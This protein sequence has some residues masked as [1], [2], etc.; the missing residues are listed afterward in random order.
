M[1]IVAQ[2]MRW[3]KKS[4]FG[5]QL[6]ATKANWL[7]SDSTNQSF[8]FVVADLKVSPASGTFGSSNLVVTAQSTISNPKPLKIYYTTDENTPTTNST[9]YVGG[10]TITNNTKLP[11]CRAIEIDKCV[12]HPTTAVINGNN[13]TNCNWQCN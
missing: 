7:P 6:S 10:I 13:D 2:K 11:I 4:A 1:K 5:T 8:N 12:Q 3:H 9:V